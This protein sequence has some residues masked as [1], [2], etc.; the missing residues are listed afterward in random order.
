MDTIITLAI[1]FLLSSGGYF[2]LRSYMND[3]YMS[4]IYVAIF[5]CGLFIL[6]YQIMLTVQKKKEENNGKI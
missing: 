4:E 3:A 5:I 1:L 2:A 6:F